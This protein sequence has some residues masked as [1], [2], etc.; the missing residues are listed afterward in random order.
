MLT[1]P[2]PGTVTVVVNTLAVTV[3]VVVDVEVV[4]VVEVDSVE[5]VVDV[6][7]VVVVDV[8]SVGVVVDVEVE[9]V[10]DEVVEVVSAFD[11][12]PASAVADNT[13]K[14]RSAPRP[15]ATRIRFMLT[16]SFSNLQVPSP[17]ATEHAHRLPESR[18]Q[19]RVRSS[20]E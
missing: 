8:E 17:S 7:V 6:E 1:R 9:S 14:A 2:K 19:P 10:E 20:T 18:V 16:L 11:A 4:V 12:L 3:E 15:S 5:V 13:P